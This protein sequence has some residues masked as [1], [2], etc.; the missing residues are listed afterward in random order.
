M[1]QP[2]WKDGLTIPQRAVFLASLKAVVDAR[3]LQASISDEAVVLGT[4]SIQL[5]TLARLCAQVRTAGYLAVLDAHIE[6]ALL[7]SHGIAASE[8]L[9][10]DWALARERIKLR[11]LPLSQIAGSED[12]LISV[13]VGAGLAAVLVYDLS[14]SVVSVRPQAAAGWPVTEEGLWLITLDNLRREEPPPQIKRLA[15]AEGVHALQ[16]TGESVFMAS[17]L[18]LLSDILSPENAPHGALAI[19]PHRHAMVLHPITDQGVYD[20]LPALSLMAR[21]MFASSPGPLSPVVYWWRFNSIEPV[22]VAVDTVAG[23]VTLS[24]SEDLLA[25]LEALLPSGRE[26]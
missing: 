11:L 17:R 2:A 6:E 16:I 25:I 18:L 13:D 14:H 20:A 26:E 7:S 1:S 5:L 22:E 3:G 19:V 15:L 21:K 23:E 10:K 12:E 9:D 24:P 4:I 8:V